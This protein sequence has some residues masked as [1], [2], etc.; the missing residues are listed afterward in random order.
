MLS[1][2]R[3]LE[4]FRQKGHAGSVSNSEHCLK[5]SKPIRVAA[6]TPAWNPVWQMVKLKTTVHDTKHC[7]C[8]PSLILL[9]TELITATLVSNMVTKKDLLQGESLSKQTADSYDSPP[10]FSSVPQDDD[11][12]FRRQLGQRKD[13]RPLVTTWRDVTWRDVEESV[14]D[15]DDDGGDENSQER[16]EVCTGSDVTDTNCLSRLSP[17]ICRTLKRAEHM[18]LFICIAMVRI[19]VIITRNIYILSYPTP[20]AKS[21]L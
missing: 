10:F 5:S 19:Y 7:S 18:T 14:G 1:C 21:T 17:W 12:H 16:D 20:F 13:E 4:P 15:D 9:I 11:H 3:Q 8:N 6:H 2:R